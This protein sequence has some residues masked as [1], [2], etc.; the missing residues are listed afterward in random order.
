MEIIDGNKIVMEHAQY[1]AIV[2]ELTYLLKQNDR[3]MNDINN[4][5]SIIRDKDET[6]NLLKEL[7]IGKEGEQ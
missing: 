6:I 2:G 5:L 3:L 4:Q 1:E 7:L